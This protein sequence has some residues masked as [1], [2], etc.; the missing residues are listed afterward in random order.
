METKLYYHAFD[1][2]DALIKFSK[3]TPL[4]SAFSAKSY[5]SV[6]YGTT[7]SFYGTSSMDEA[8]DLLANGYP[9]GL[10]NLLTGEGIVYN[11]NTRP[12]VIRRTDYVGQ[13]PHIANTIMGLPKTMVRRVRTEQPV[14]FITINYDVSAGAKV[15][16]STIARGGKNLM[17]LIKYLESNGFKVQLN[18]VFGSFANDKN[19]TKRII[20]FTSVTIKRYSQRLNAL[21]VSYP[22][23]HPSFFRRHMLHA[24]EC[25]PETTLSKFV[26][27]HGMVWSTPHFD[28]VGEMRN[29]RRWNEHDVYIKYDDIADAKSI[30]D[31]VRVV[32]VNTTKVA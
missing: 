16:S 2:V 22:I 13:R 4:N 1:S 7:Q 21:L 19:Y 10:E 11:Q 25:Y 8:N 27:N 15:V 28:V 5:N 26:N 29:L 20:A 32:N 30:Y 24:L 12:K 31:L 6:L 9:Q 23:T 3:D 18:M 17:A 14:K